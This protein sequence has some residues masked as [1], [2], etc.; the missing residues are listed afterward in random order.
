[1]TKNINDCKEYFIKKIVDIIIKEPRYNK[2]DKIE[3]NQQVDP[4]IR[5]II[6]KHLT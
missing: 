3:P 6:N 4:L 1:M 2:N 5:E